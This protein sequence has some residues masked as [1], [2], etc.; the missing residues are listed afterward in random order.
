MTNSSSTTA[1]GAFRLG[2]AWVE[3][4]SLAIRSADSELRLAPKHMAVLQL[5][6]DHAPA[7]VTR[8]E[9]FDAVW[10]RGFVNPAV[11]ANAISAL[12][13]ALAINGATDV[14]ETIP[15]R[16]Y[17][18]TQRPSVPPVDAVPT[19][20]RGSPYLGL[21]PFQ[22]ADSDVFFGREIEVEEIAVAL[23]EQAA[24]GCAFVLILGP[25]GSGKTS[26]V[27]AGL[28]PY[29]LKHRADS[30]FTTVCIGL[31]RGGPDPWSALARAFAASTEDAERLALLLRDD[32]DTA[33]TAI[34]SRLER[35]A[36]STA[37]GLISI[38]QLELLF[39]SDEPDVEQFLQTLHGLTRSGRVWIVAT[40]RSDFYP[41]CVHSATL[42]NMMRGH[43]HYDLGPPGAQ[44]IGRII[45][46]PA[47][48]AGVRFE[49]T[50]NTE[51]RL[52]DI[53]HAEAAAQPEVL[54]LLE[55]TL[56]ELYARRSD[57]GVLTY[58]AYT[59]LGGVG[60]CLARRAEDAFGALSPTVQKELDFVFQQLAHVPSQSGAGVTRRFVVRSVVADT[61]ARQQ[62]VDA[63]I[64]AR[65]F[66]T[67]VESGNPVVSVTHEALFR[68]WSR[69]SESLL[70]NRTALLAKQ[71][72]ASATQLWLDSGRSSAYLLAR[73]PLDESEQA[74]DR[75]TMPIEGAESDL[76]HASRGRLL[77]TARLRTAAVVALV[78]V[79]CGAILAAVSAQRQRLVADAQ[80]QRAALAT[81]S[82]LDIFRL[83]DPGQQRLDDVSA[84][85]LFELGVRQV[86]AGFVRD[87]QLQARLKSAIGT[88]YSNLGR[89]DQAEAQLVQAVEIAREQAA[90]EPLLLA[91][92]LNALG[93]LR[94]HQSRFKE[95]R[96]YYEEAEQLTKRE[97]DAGRPALAQTL[98][99]LGE[100]EVALGNFPAA[101]ALH[102]RALA[103]RTA[104]FGADSADA[105]TSWQNLAGVLRQSGQWPE[106]E[107]AYRR[108]LA[109]QEA[110]LG[111]NH[112]EVAVS[113]TNLGLLL[114]E[115]GRF[116]EAEP[117]QRRA[118]AIRE[119]MLGDAHPQ[120]A[121]SL[122]NLSAL[123]FSSGD[124]VRAEPML[125]ESVQRH[126]AIFGTDH[127][128][129]AY[130]RNNL[131]TLLLETGRADEAL[132][133]FIQ[134]HASIEAL[135]GDEHPNAALLDANLA[136]ALLARGQIEEARRHAEHAFETLRTRLPAGH[137]RIAAAES[138]LGATLLKSGELARAEPHL[139]ASWKTLQLAQSADAPT[140][141]AA[142]ERV[143]ELYEAQGDRPAATS[144]RA[145]LE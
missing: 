132:P 69:L 8:T 17:R 77:R 88:V 16:G 70:R 28:I 37:T 13:K 34:V 136:K 12:R 19:W 48:A 103:I 80:S 3:P 23:G 120:T 40:M 108:A 131:A 44:Q 138:I 72:L 101:E 106:S 24:A 26:L 74:V 114:T 94:Y 139:L 134:A 9:L 36:D 56:D 130:G 64:A 95:S 27:R 90:S 29:L 100:L 113:L 102:R 105:A 60:G 116:E 54:P 38:D 127:A 129:V 65:L 31:S 2:N 109:A 79:S 125:R 89:Q 133:L 107:R 51:E 99:N 21:N 124:Y 93:K 76:I 55:F 58:A 52:D 128:S 145:S 143:A 67:Q 119:A 82:L 35:D 86:D 144:L 135:L 33:V 53:L 30:H 141:R 49:S 39:D 46:A 1:P 4:D 98:N 118:L 11:L 41:L 22:I 87:R 62:L 83:A 73:G 68:H 111:A 122:H 7:I 121:H 123:L 42:R 84:S 10:P 47:A 91:G 20:E 140:R 18:L 15:K 85:E 50:A 81:Q 59:S 115:A 110:T 112:P 71:R 6:A 63:F 25:S 45:R 78:I 92:T 43:G 75:L 57:N 126:E 66:V 96:P 32:I 137:W 142:L 14:I 61:A 117:L 5:L 97:G 104:V